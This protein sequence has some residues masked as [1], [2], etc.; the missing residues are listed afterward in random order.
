MDIEIIESSSKELKFKTLNKT[1]LEILRVYL[2]KRNVEFVAWAREHPSRPAIMSI[3]TSE[4][5]I[6]K[7]ISEAISDIK[8]DCEKLISLSKK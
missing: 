7:A 6:K 1:I 8:K 5:T 2:N 4:G 3:K